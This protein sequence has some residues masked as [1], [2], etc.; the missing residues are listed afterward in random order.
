VIHIVKVVA[1]SNYIITDQLF[2]PS[3]LDE[4]RFILFNDTALF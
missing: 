4:V 2:V 3:K 1:R